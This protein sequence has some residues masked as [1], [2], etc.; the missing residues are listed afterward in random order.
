MSS[1]RPRT[2]PSGESHSTGADRNDDASRRQALRIAS[3][4]SARR[5]AY[6]SLMAARISASTNAR[7]AG[8]LVSASIDVTRDARSGGIRRRLQVDAESQ[9]DELKL[10]ALRRRLGQN[11]GQLAPADDDVVRPFDFSRQSGDSANG[12]GNGNSAASV[13]SAAGWSSP[14]QAV[15]RPQDHRHVESGARRRKP[16]SAM[17]AATRRSA[18]RQPPSCLLRRQAARGV[19]PRRW[20][21]RWSRAS[22]SAGRWRRAVRERARARDT[23]RPAV[24]ANRGRLVRQ[25][26]FQS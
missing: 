6:R 26:R 18:S 16:H 13:S 2:T 10:P 1:A 21:S 4:L 3:N 7:S 23:R 8:R 19:R 11:A 9:H 25:V 17:P 5:S 15:G 20:S 14:R 12:F 24:A 22:E